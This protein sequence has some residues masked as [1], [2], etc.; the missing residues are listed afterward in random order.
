MWLDERC[1]DW[2]E[3]EMKAIES[4]EE[5]ANGVSIVPVSNRFLRQ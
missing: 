3:T 1:R 2:W 4:E 5:Q